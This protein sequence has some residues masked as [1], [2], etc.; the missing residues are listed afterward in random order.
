MV[1]GSCTA[2]AAYIPTM[3]NE[4]VVVDEIGTIFLA[5][6][7]L[8]YAAIGEQVSD[9]DLGGAVVHCEVSGCADYKASNEMEALEYT[10]DIMSTL[11][12]DI[13][14][15]KSRHVEEPIFDSEDL[16]LLALL[17]DSK[18]RLKMRQ[19]LSRVIDGSRFHEYKPNYGKE[20]ITGYARVSGILVGII[21]NDGRFS[22]QSCLKASN[23][24]S[25]CSERGI[26]LVFFQDIVKSFD[27][28]SATKL[29]KHQAELM[30]YVATASVPKITF[31]IGKSSGVENYA[32]AG[33]SMSPNFLYLWPTSEI[34][35]DQYM[36]SGNDVD[37]TG[38]QSKNHNKNNPYYS[39]SRIWD[40]GVILPKDT[41]KILSLSLTACLTYKKRSKS[42]INVVRM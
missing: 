17:R 16:L 21:A 1:A 26:P 19:I 41:R 30:S 37:S 28:S 40:D 23:F 8:V 18:G 35:C 42:E 13:Y 36:T 5:G 20:I 9:Q 3:A 7:P 15:Q 4:V 33:R 27:D 11:N 29:I 2:G 31:I 38:N 34:I 14:L 12:M 10:K 39:S 25:I 32:M 24:V 22:P 6:P